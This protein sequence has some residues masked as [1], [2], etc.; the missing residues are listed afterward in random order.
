MEQ[1]RN[2][3]KNAI[4]TLAMCIPLSASAAQLVSNGGFETGDFTGWTATAISSTDCF[5]DWNVS[6]AGGFAAT[7]C[8]GGGN[9]GL[10]NPG[11]PGAGTY[12]AY[13]SF[14]GAGPLTYSLRQVIA[15]PAGLASAA[16]SWIDTAAWDIAT[17]G[18]PTALPRDF[19]VN[20][21]DAAGTTLL[22]NLYTFSIDGTA[23][24]DIPWTP[25][26]VD[27]LGLLGPLGGT[28]VT[29]AFENIVP[30]EFT[31]PAGFGLDSV[32]LIVT[33]PE[34]GTLA[35]LGLGLAGLAASRRRKQ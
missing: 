2:S 13:N 23:I 4:L 35:L 20:I 27:A 1:R 22:G 26:S 14:D 29:L 32:E 6:A 30:Q 11:A 12:S 7:A 16:V 24:G 34:P 19:V 31:G 18:G 9:F 8:A 5:T 10:A 25:R 21:Y 28:T 33:V 17:F 15:L 3:L